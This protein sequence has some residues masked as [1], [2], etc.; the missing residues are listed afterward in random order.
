ME[1]RAVQSTWLLL[2]AFVLCPE[3]GM[4]LGKGL[5]HESDE[6]WLRELGSAQ[7]GEK[8]DQGDLL[9]LSSSLTRGCSQ[10]GVVLVSQET[11]D[12]SR[13]NSHKLCQG[14]FRL[15]C[16]QCLHGNVFPAL[17]QGGI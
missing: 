16:E 15:T 3:V 1:R 17:A 10:V 13:G 2:L 14:R 12:G 7:P 5:E 4:E 8:E 11:V 6:E 9:A